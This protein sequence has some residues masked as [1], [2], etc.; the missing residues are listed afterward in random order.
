MSAFS[1]MQTFRNNAVKDA[2]RAEALLIASWDDPDY[3]AK[4]PV[5]WA[6]VKKFLDR[7]GSTYEHVHKGDR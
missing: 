4:R 6:R 3:R 1:Q 2:E 5:L 7:T